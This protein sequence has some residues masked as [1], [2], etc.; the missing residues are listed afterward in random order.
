MDFDQIVRLSTRRQMLQAAATVA[1]G[2]LLSQVGY[3]ENN[4][5]KRDSDDETPQKSS[6]APPGWIAVTAGGFEGGSRKP[7]HWE[8]DLYGLE[9]AKK[10]ECTPSADYRIV[11]DST[12]PSKGNVLEIVNPGT[13]AFCV[14]SEVLIRDG[15]VEVQGKNTP[16]TQHQLGKSPKAPTLGVVWRYQNPRS[17]Y[18]V[19]FDQ[20]DLKMFKMEDEEFEELETGPIIRVAGEQWNTVRVEF[21]GHKFRVLLNGGELY[22]AFDD[23]INA[24][25]SVG[26]ACIGDSNTHFDNF[27]YAAFES[28]QRADFNEMPWG[29]PREPWIVADTLDSSNPW[30]PQKNAMK[31]DIFKIRIPHGP[32]ERN[33]LRQSGFGVMPVCVNSSVKLLNGYLEA[34]MMPYSGEFERDCGIVWRYQDAKNY[35]LARSEFGDPRGWVVL[36]KVVD[37]K[38][39]AIERS[40]IVDTKSFVWHGI[41][42][43]FAGNQIAVYYD[44]RLVI[45]A[46]DT[47]LTKPGAVGVWTKLDGQA[48]FDNLSW[49]DFLGAGWGKATAKPTGGVFEEK[50]E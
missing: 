1:G 30:Y 21:T 32:S 35:Y 22:T 8:R 23:G 45:S 9:F 34:D 18:C 6:Q 31:W 15:Y 13:D 36:W 41:R 26:V 17:F 38:R 27:K 10:L 5:Q 25:G 2:G 42:A 16:A 12:A 3:A 11:A 28:S 33:A 39:T 4:A 50:K 43:E 46:A 44:N 48:L 20:S 29:P 47:A 40:R 19:Y 14:K 49:G 7:G 37:G 24:P